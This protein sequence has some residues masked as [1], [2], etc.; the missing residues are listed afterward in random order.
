MADATETPRPIRRFAIVGGWA[1]VNDETGEDTRF[2]ICVTTP[3][4][5]RDLVLEVRDDQL[6]ITPT[7]PLAR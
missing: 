7:A 6:L 5:P 3:V 4:G 1:D 2:V